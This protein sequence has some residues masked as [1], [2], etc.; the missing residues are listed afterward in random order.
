M[1]AARPALASG[2]WRRLL[3]RAAIW[4]VLLLLLLVAALLS[5]AFVRPVYLLN[6]VR[7]AAP[8]SRRC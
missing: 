7:Q 2:A 8:W 4:L 6:V 5:D 1:S 3:D